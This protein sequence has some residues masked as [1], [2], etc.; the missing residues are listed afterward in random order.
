MN[1]V[2][3]ETNERMLNIKLQTQKEKVSYWEQINLS[4]KDDELQ[5]GAVFDKDME[6]IE[7]LRIENKQQFEKNVRL[8]SKCVKQNQKN[9]SLRNKKDL[10]ERSWSKLNHL[11]N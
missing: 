2:E 5:K 10:K 9:V 11:T 7:A 8:A 1:Q 4:Q 3:L 6:T